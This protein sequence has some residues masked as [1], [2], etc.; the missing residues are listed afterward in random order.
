[1]ITLS[2][3]FETIISL[4]SVIILFF[5]LNRL[6]FSL[7]NI[8]LAFVL[9]IPI[10]ILIATVITLTSDQLL[11]YMDEPLYGLLLAIVFLR[12]LP[13]TLLVFYGFF[14]FTLKNLFL[15]VI[16]YFILPL[17]DQSSGKM[18]DTL[19][20]VLSVLGSTF[21]V[22]LFLKWLSYDFIKLRTD[23]LDLADKQVL[24]LSNWAMSFY[25][26]LM[27]ILT[28]LEYEK[29]IIT[30]IYRQFLL[31]I[32]LIIFMGI[33][34]QLDAHLKN[35][36]Q[37]QLD[38]QRQLQLKNMEKYSSHVEELYREVR[39]FRHDYANLLTTLRLGI[40]NNDIAQ[41]KEIYQ[42]VLKDSHK[43]LKNRKYD[44]GR[45]I[46]IDNAALK[47]LLATK[48]IQASESDVL[49]SL[50]IPEIIRPQG[51]DLVD[52]ITIVSILFDNAIEA[53]ITADTPKIAIAFLDINDRQRFI[54]EN[55]T[56]EASVD[57]SE[58]YSFGHSSKGKNRGVGLYNV[59]KI[60]EHYPN[61]SLSTSSRNHLFCQIVEIMK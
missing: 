42:S 28:Y 1:M 10:A 57:I 14:A 54:I 60:I 61:V 30:Q 41:I 39:G 38:F 51:M 7:S 36:L 4:A 58:I 8:L 9:R 25:Y 59:M 37:E 15:R 45:L 21:L 27:Q 48:F 35:K 46:N 34:K 50:E 11:S 29:G 18:E 40:E 23:S 5:S 16:T 53:G 2:Y 24:Y 12:P 44:M 26:I 22:F 55:T 3:V 6:R 47:S 19:I 49:V 33:I 31:V 56:N 17:F 32:Y 20:Y 13:K 43:K 52:F